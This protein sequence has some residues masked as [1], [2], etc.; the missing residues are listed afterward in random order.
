MIAIISPSFITSYLSNFI[1]NRIALYYEVIYESNLSVATS[2]IGSSTSILSPTSFN[3]FVI[4][5]STTLSPMLGR[6]IKYLPIFTS[7]MENKFTK[8]KKIKSIDHKILG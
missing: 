3:Q 8:I 7:L 2:T 1:S 4:V 5:A 6:V